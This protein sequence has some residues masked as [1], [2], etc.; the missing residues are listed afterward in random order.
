L[1]LVP[2]EHQDGRA[3]VLIED[4]ASRN[5]LCVNGHRTGRALLESG[6]EIQIGRSVLRLDRVDAYERALVGPAVAPVWMSME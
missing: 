5:G 3:F 4:L 2:G 1:S 6:D